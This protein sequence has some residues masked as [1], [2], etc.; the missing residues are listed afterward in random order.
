MEGTVVGHDLERSIGGRFV[1][2]KCVP[3]IW[4]IYCIYIYV[5]ILYLDVMNHDSSI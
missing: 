1:P 4:M 2:C 3:S 5:F